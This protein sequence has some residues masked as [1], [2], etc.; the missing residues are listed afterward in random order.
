MWSR[1]GLCSHLVP[2]MTMVGLRVAAPKLNRLDLRSYD[3][4]ILRH[5]QPLCCDIHVFDPFAAFIRQI[6][7]FA[8]FYHVP[9]VTGYKG[10]TQ[11]RCYG[12][13]ISY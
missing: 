4:N 7:T 1:E 12:Q 2:A 13:T 5:Q 6:N 11:Y 8:F 9:Q 10:F 3:I